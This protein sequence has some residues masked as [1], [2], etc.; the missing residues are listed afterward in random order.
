[1]NMK[2]TLLPTLALVAVSAGSALAADL[3]YRKAPVMA[4]AVVS[5]SWTGCYIAGG[6]GYG[7][8]NQENTVFAGGV[9]IS[10]ETTS[11]GRGWFGTVQGGC[12]YQIAPRWVVGVFGDYD[13]S[14]IKGT[15]SVLGF[16]GEEKL[17]SS[18]GVGGRVGYLILPQLLTY[19]AVGYT[20]ANFGQIDVVNVAGFSVAE[21]TYSGWF[22]G[23]GY[24]YNLG[25]MP[26]LFWKT[27]Y[28][29]A[30]YDTDRNVILAGGAPTI[31]TADQQKFVQT[32]RSA[33]VWRWNWGR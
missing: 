7:M 3:P 14:S 24:E 25:W 29:A 19:V 27:E 31:F 16:Y 22:I 13:F 8:W 1:M 2:K 26:G 33:L 17:E 11:G 9:Q 32:V 15:P 20:E 28:R 30:E 5:T 4:P 21:H 10:P 12:D 23:T 6:G 18:W